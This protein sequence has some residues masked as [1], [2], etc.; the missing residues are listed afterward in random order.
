MESLF[1]ARANL[2]LAIVG[3]IVGGIGFLSGWFGPKMSRSYLLG[4]VVWLVSG[5]CLATSLLR[6]L[7]SES[8]MGRQRI[9]C[10]LNGQILGKLFVTFAKEG[11]HFPAASNWCDFAITNF[12]LSR[13]ELSCPTLLGSNACGQA[14]NVNVAGHTISEVPGD[15]VLLFESRASWNAAGGPELFEPHGHS[16]RLT[17]VVFADGSSR[18]VALHEVGKLRWTP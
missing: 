14:Y 4:V 18:R 9:T 7:E 3:S 8:L 11:G 10:R 1:L 2:G 13:R 15:C 16:W 12:G 5:A 17:Q 6:A